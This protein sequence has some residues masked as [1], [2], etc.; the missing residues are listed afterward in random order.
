MAFYRPLAGLALLGAS[1]GGPYLVF[2]ASKPQSDAPSATQTG[3][4]GRPV[5]QALEQNQVANSSWNSG[6]IDFGASTNP[7]SAQAGS[8]LPGGATSFPQYRIQAL[9]EILRFDVSPHW[10]PQRFSRVSTVLG[11]MNL[12]GLRVPLVTGTSTS[13][14][15]GTLTYYFDPYQR[16]QRIK[17]HAVTGDPGRFIAELQHAYQLQQQPALGGQLYLKKWNGRPTSLVYTTSAP[18][19]DAED[20]FARYSLFIELNQGGLE[21]GLSQEA[22]ELLAQGSLSNRW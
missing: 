3:D 7:A 17:L 4:P 12:D 8:L 2:E 19:L 1:V 21:Y 16:V 22:N 9:Q 11:D 6:S 20:A 15:A 5:S 18:V 14:L 10:L 13:D